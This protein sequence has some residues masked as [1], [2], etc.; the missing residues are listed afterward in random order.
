MRIE[1]NKKTI[2]GLIP[3]QNKKTFYYDLGVKGLVLII[4]PIKR[5]GRIIRSWYYSYRPKGLNPV[6]HF[7][8]PYPLLSVPAARLKAKKVLSDV[9]NQKDP[10]LIKQK[11]KTELTVEQLVKKF[12]KE[13]CIHY[14]PKTRAGWESLLNLWVLHQAK[15]IGYQQYFTKSIKDKKIST[16]TVKDI[17]ELFRSITLKSTYS[18]NRVIEVLR[19]MFNWAIQQGLSL[20]QPVQFTRNKNDKRKTMFNPERISNKTFSEEERDLILK[21]VL[22]L[23]TRTGQID[24]DYYIQ[25]Q[26]S[27]ISC[28][29]IAWCLLTGRRQRSEGFCITFDQISLSTAT[30]HFDDTKTGEADYDLSP[31]AVAMIRAIEKSKDKQICYPEKRYEMINKK[32]GKKYYKIFPSRIAANPWENNT[33]NFVFPSLMSKTG[34]ITDVKR[35]WAQVLRKLGIQYLPLKQCRH[36]F[37]TLLLS[38]SGSLTAVQGALGHTNARTTERYAKILRKDIKNAL[39]NFCKKDDKKNKVINF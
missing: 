34:H 15:K 14:K 5:N 21:T 23:D 30:I 37:G 33:G 16:V 38:H 13:Q 28:L 22:V 11:L 27:I 12:L 20:N 18:A 32:N 9:L 1:L 6:R 35:T 10:A 3:H 39:V 4:D 17:Q 25:N 31:D 36:T 7:L 26:L 2:E 24:F 29:V 19:V 8:G